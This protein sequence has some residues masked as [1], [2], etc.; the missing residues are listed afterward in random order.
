METAV[1]Q[2]STTWYLAEGAT[3]GSFDLFYLIQ[4]PSRRPRP[5]ASV[6]CGRGRADREDLHRRRRQPVH[7]LGRP[8]RPGRSPATDVSAEF[9]ST[10][11]VP[12]IV[13]R[14]MYLITRSRRSR[15]AQQRGRDRAGD[16]A[17]SWPRARPAASSRC[18][19]LVANPTRPRRRCRRR[20]SAPAAPPSS[21]P[22]R[23]PPTA[24]APSTSPARTGPGRHA[25]VG[26]VE[27]TNGVPVIVE[28]TMWWTAPAP[29]WT[30]GHNAFGTTRTAPR[31]LLAEGE[32]GGARAIST[33]V[34]VAN[35][36]AADPRR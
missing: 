11:G 29:D 1:E 21:R 18:I 16:R 28:R 3:H 31:W 4:N 22:T 20:S 13:E 19:M 10:N 26:Q 17:G 27:S 15:A 35:T 23:S 7:H 24:A 8:G 14:S 5:S 33:F 30:E 6:T 32:H 34:L 12:V 36:S 25:G 9:T 2:P